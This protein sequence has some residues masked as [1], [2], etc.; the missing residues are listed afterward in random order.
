MDISS[1]KLTYHSLL[2]IIFRESKVTLGTH[3]ET[4]SEYLLKSENNYST[5]M[6]AGQANSLEQ[7]SFTESNSPNKVGIDIFND[8]TQGPGIVI[9]TIIDYILRVYYLN[10]YQDL[11]YQI[12]NFK[13]FFE[14]LLKKYNE[15]YN[16]DF[17]YNQL[18]YYQN[19]YTFLNVDILDHS[20]IIKILEYFISIL[21]QDKIKEEIKNELI[22]T[23][24]LNSSV[25]IKSNNETDLP[26]NNN[27]ILRYVDENNEEILNN[28]KNKEFKQKVCLV[29]CSSLNPNYD[30]NGQFYNN[31]INKTILEAQYEFSLYMTIYNIIYNL[32]NLDIDIIKANL[33]SMNKLFITNI[34]GGVFGAL[35]EHIEHSKKFI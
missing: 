6:V 9:P 14:N 34:G 22:C 29:I 20:T 7:L 26:K 28:L 30:R 4:V 18:F 31:E 21:K 1:I 13:N 16:E 15:E 3:I 19:G 23:S 5:F 8:P 33:G 24:V 32:E 11:N 12:N 27:Q 25:I 35:E 2:Q 17:E 10:N